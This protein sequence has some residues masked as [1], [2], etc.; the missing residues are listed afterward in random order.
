MKLLPGKEVEYKKRHDEI[1]PELT[2]LLKE[3]GVKEYSIFLDNQDLTLFGTLTTADPVV[4]DR[5]PSSPIMR[6]WWQ[7]MKDIMETN[8]DGSPVAIPMQE[9]FYLP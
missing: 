8:D 7:F 1:W 3:H 5:L 2:A 9:V 6:R 4:H